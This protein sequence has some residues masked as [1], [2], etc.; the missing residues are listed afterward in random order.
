MCVSSERSSLLSR[1]AFMGAV[2][3]AAL[4]LFCEPAR[5]LDAVQS[6][7]GSG[8]QLLVPAGLLP[9]NKRAVEIASSSPL[10]NAL[11]AQAFS[12]AQSIG[13]AKLR[14]DVVELLREPVAR[15]Q[16]KYATPESRAALR[17]ELVRGGFIAASASIDSLFP[18]ISGPIGSADAALI[19]NGS[20]PP[21]SP[22]LSPRRPRSPG[23]CPS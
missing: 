13:D 19:G 18:P 21:I 20:A 5:A 17:D 2:S 8:Q 12:L 3:A 23:A 9:G 4:P 11:T 1:S 6:A 22:Q 15:Y 14:S 10:M 16:Q 7:A